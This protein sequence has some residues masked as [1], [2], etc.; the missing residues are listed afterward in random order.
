MCSLDFCFI[1]LYLAIEKKNVIALTFHLDLIRYFLFEIKLIIVL[2]DL[3]ACDN[4]ILLFYF[5]KIE[6]IVKGSR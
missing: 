6:N 2:Q 5:N 1:A 3:S 4:E